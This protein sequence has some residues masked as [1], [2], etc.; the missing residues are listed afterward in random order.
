MYLFLV[1]IPYAVNTSN[2]SRESDPAAFA[3]RLPASSSSRSVPFARVPGSPFIPYEIRHCPCPHTHYTVTLSTESVALMFLC[4]RGLSHRMAV[5]ADGGHALCFLEQPPR[6]I[7][8]ED[9]PTPGATTPAV[10]IT[11]QLSSS[12]QQF[13]T[14]HLAT[15]SA[16]LGTSPAWENVCDE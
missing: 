10:L 8:R 5:S 12:A 14:D 7:Y 1:F 11:L 6:H 13:L 15:S 3:S 4:L 2:G 16:R 9:P